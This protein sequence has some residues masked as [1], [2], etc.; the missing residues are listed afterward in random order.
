MATD[1]DVLAAVDRLRAIAAYDLFHPDLAA[2]LQQI[3][4]ATAA[5]LGAPMTAVQA[6]L[7]TATAT[8]ATN[9][10]EGDF[11]AALGGSPNEFSFCPQVV[12]DR[13]PFV[14]DDLA[15]VPAYADNPGVRAGLVRSYAGT[16]LILPTGEVLGSHCAMSPQTHTFTEGELATLAEAAA[17]VMTVIARYKKPAVSHLHERPGR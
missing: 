15:A 5:R 12:I 11:L 2:E 13:A 6:V 3:C 16:P 9:A 4:E 1:L 7:D 17:K 10:G 8:L 14:R